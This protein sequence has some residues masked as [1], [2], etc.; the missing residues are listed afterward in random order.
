[1][2]RNESPFYF[3]ALEALRPKKGLV[4]EDRALGF[5]DITVLNDLSARILY[6]PGVVRVPEVKKDFSVAEYGTNWTIW[7][8]SL[9]D[10]PQ[11]DFFE[12]FKVPKSHFEAAG[13]DSM[14]GYYQSFSSGKNS[15][16]AP[17]EDD[18]V[19]IYWFDNFRSV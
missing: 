4:Y 5:E 14:D 15:W 19:S 10:I 7:K 17:A 1:M 9:V 12:L 16:L 18:L 13:F 6:L 11:V 8:E 2:M 3:S